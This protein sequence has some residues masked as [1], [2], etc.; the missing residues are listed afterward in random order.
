MGTLARNGLRKVYDENNTVT[1]IPRSILYLCTKHEYF[2]FNGEIY[3]QCDGVAM[4]SPLGP[5]SA[6]VFMISLEENI[7]PK[8]QS[9][10]YN[11]RTMLCGCLTNVTQIHKI[12]TMCSTSGKLVLSGN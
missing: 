5:L 11:W 7:L 12:V 3:I 1:N 8:L 10:L 4:D 6:N 2:K 9:Y